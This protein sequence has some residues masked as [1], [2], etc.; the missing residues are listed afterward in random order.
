MT[1]PIIRVVVVATSLGVASVVTPPS[2]PNVQV[3]SHVEQN[4]EYYPATTAFFRLFVEGDSV[5]VYKMFNSQG[6]IERMDMTSNDY[7]TWLIRSFG[8]SLG[9]MVIGLTSLIYIVL[10]G[11]SLIAVTG[12]YLIP[13]SLW[14][15]YCL[16]GV[17][18]RTSS[19]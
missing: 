3:F 1:S 4:H 12:T 11:I 8:L 19:S 16:L 14:A 15:I 9:A 10:A 7:P 17:A 2:L 18:E 6:L 5:E 13:V